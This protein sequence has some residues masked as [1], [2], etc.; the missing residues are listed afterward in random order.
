MAKSKK[1]GSV[2]RGNSLLF[3]IIGLCS[4]ISFMVTGILWIVQLIPGATIPY[5]A[6]I[7]SVSNLILLIA[8]FAAG[9]VWLVSCRMNRKL[10]LV[11]K[12]MFCV[13]AVLAILGIFGLGV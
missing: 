9:W 11:L 1:E 13:F 12:I 3:W 10:K 4:F 5:L 6:Q 2:K 8:A 7:K